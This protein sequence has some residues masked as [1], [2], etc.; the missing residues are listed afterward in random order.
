M[1]DIQIERWLQTFQH[2][3]FDKLTF[4]PLFKRALLI[5][6]DAWLRCL[7]EDVDRFTSAYYL[8]GSRSAATKS[9]GSKTH[10]PERI[11]EG[12]EQEVDEEGDEDEDEEEE[13][14]VQDKAQPLPVA[15]RSIP[16]VHSPETQINI[17][18]NMIYIKRP[19]LM[20]F[21]S[22]ATSERQD[23]LLEAL[24]NAMTDD[25]RQRLRAERKERLRR[26]EEN[27][28]KALKAARERRKR[29]AKEKEGTDASSDKTAQGR[30]TEITLYIDR[31]LPHKLGPMQSKDAQRL[32]SSDM[33]RYARASKTPY[34]NF[35]QKFTLL[36]DISRVGSSFCI[37][38]VSLILASSGWKPMVT[39]KNSCSWIAYERLSSI[40]NRNAA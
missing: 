35:E 36:L 30:R 22:S 11:R 24:E 23:R 16:R 26:L 34:P 12:G 20:R 2:Y 9:S 29:L 13:R 3:R 14:V 1:P 28:K 27:R 37:D 39:T 5:L 15:R 17:S 33:Q 8:T 21:I 38:P 32:F 6:K 31:L 19:W 10:D 7:K 18:N 25:E 4:E 40:R